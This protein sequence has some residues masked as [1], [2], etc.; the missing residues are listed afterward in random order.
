MFK[1]EKPQ[2]LTTT[3]VIR[4]LNIYIYDIFPKCNEFKIQT[5][6]NLNAMNCTLF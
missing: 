2:C 1:L 5:L 4:S 6:I 3:M